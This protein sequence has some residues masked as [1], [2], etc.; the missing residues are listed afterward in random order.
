MRLAGSVRQEKEERVMGNKCVTVLFVCAVAAGMLGSLD[1]SEGR[2]VTASSEKQAV[3]GA[4]CLTQSV[5]T[6]WMCFGGGN[7][8]S[9]CT[10]CGCSLDHPIS[11]PFPWGLHGAVTARCNTLP[12]CTTVFARG[13]CSGG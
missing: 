11:G 7:G 9:D 12:E 10:G 1:G 6:A 3:W 5:T 13:S 2:H 4:A 8:G